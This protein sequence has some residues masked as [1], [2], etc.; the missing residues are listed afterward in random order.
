MQP[1][2][3][4]RP[5]TIGLKRR[6][7]VELD[8]HIAEIRC[9]LSQF[10]HHSFLQ[11]VQVMDSDGFLQLTCWPEVPTNSQVAQGIRNSVAWSVGNPTLGQC[12]NRACMMIQSLCQVYVKRLTNQDG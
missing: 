7:R 1:S 12:S 3:A 2:R 11:F 8:P 10:C 9:V 6:N 4:A 5:R